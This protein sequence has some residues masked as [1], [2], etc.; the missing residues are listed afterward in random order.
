[1]LL[2]F[3][4]FIFYGDDV[5]VFDR[6]INWCLFYYHENDMFFGKDRKYDAGENERMMAELNERKKKYPQFRHPYL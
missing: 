1:M 6:S 3:S 5:A 2:R 4:P